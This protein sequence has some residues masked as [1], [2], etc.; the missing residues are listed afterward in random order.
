[1]MNLESMEKLCSLSLLIYRSK[2]TILFTVKGK[3]V[4][5]TGQ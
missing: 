3:L 4:G 1:M 5:V 2:R